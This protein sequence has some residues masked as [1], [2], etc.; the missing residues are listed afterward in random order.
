MSEQEMQNKIEFIVEQQANFA[1]NLQKLQEEQAKAESRISR[2][3]RAV[4]TVVNL[5]GELTK[6][7]KVTDAKMNELSEKV[8]TVTDRLDKFTERVD[9]LTERMDTF[10]TVMVERFFGDQNG[11]EKKPT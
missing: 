5:I 6:A 4:V 2:I 3:E 11:K 10:I 7:Q 8:N 1:I 9:K